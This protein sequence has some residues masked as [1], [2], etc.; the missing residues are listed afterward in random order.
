MARSEHAAAVEQVVAARLALRRLGPLDLAMLEEGYAVQQEANARLE[1]Q[2]GKRVGHKIG[3]TTAPMR[4][5]INVPDPV[6]G[7]IFASTVFG[8]GASLPRGD[9]V[10]P[11]V[12]TEIAV[13]LGQP[14]AP[15]EAAYARDEVG[16]AVDGVM[17]AIEVVDDRYTDFR[18]VG[19]ATLVAD[20]AFNAASILGTPIVDLAGIDLGRLQ[21]RTFRDGEEIAS[22]WSEMLLG[23]PLDALAWI[24]N[25]RST[26]GLGLAAGDFISL[27]SITPVQWVEGKTRYRIEVDALGSVDVAFT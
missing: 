16:A 4:A 11:G 15:R 24:A 1:N 23:H 18:T 3:G 8:S 5:Y 25:R 7:E 21:A 2:L 20:N 17:A 10:R 6:A 19:A 22:G 14:L 26:L 12:E 9:F 27:G 13:R